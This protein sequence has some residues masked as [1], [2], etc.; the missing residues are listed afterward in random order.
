M[1][2]EAF[3][4]NIHFSENSLVMFSLPEYCLQNANVEISQEVLGHWTVV[5]ERTKSPPYDF[6]I[7][8]GISQ[9]YLGYLTAHSLECAMCTSVLLLRTNCRSPGFISAPSPPKKQF[10]KM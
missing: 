4:S 5:P 9:A 7:N 8:G 1:H 2:S 6:R 10:P 3:R